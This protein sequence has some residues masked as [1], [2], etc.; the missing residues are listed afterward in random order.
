MQTASLMSG[1]SLM[2]NALS[3][4]VLTLLLLPSVCRGGNPSGGADKVT[5]VVPL[6]KHLFS[7]DQAIE[8]SIYTGAQTTIVREQSNCV[9]EHLPGLAKDRISCP[10]GVAYREVKPEKISFGFSRFDSVINVPSKSIKVGDKYELHIK[11]KARDRCNARSAQ[12]QGSATAN[13]VVLTD[14]AWAQTQM[15]CAPASH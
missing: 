2:K 12:R 11:G 6:N 3:V 14:L 7:P 8:V 5:F 1:I 15:A 4:F 13:I 9:V 10:P